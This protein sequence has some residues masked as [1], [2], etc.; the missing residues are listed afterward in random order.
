MWFTQAES[1]SHRHRPSLY[2]SMNVKKG[3][4]V[5]EENVR[6]VRPG[7]GLPPKEFSRVLGKTF[8][9]AI[10]A[11]KPLSWNDLQ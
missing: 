11:G 8:V 1:E 9:S 4:V 7:G 10:P 5:S 3:E 2:V 6:S